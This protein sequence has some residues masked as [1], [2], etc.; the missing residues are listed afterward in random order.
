MTCILGGYCHL[1]DIRRAQ[2][3][4]LLTVLRL[5]SGS[6]LSFRQNE[7]FLFEDHIIYFVALYLALKTHTL[8]WQKPPVNHADYSIFQTR[9]SSSHFLVF[10]T[11]LE[12]VYWVLPQMCCPRLQVWEKKAFPVWKTQLDWNQAMETLQPTTTVTINIDVADCHQISS[13]WHQRLRQGSGVWLIAVQAWS[14]TVTGDVICTVLLLEHYLYWILIHCMDGSRRSF[15]DTDYN[16]PKRNFMKWW[17][18]LF[19]FNFEI[20][21][22]FHAKHQAVS[23]YSIRVDQRRPIPIEDDVPLLKI[24]DG[25]AKGENSKSKA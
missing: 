9:L 22:W 18:R 12:R 24:A 2:S 14:A 8:F 21:H 17:V 20:S 11:Y 10:I 4:S 5:L 15:E 13:V 6:D 16:G 19:Q 1:F 23:C 3:D 7:C 25:Q